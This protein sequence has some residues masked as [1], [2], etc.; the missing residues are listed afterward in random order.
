MSAG[1]EKMHVS[2]NGGTVL[3]A[4]FN[5]NADAPR[6]VRAALAD[7]CGDLDRELGFRLKFLVS[8]AVTNRVLD[9]ALGGGRGRIHVGFSTDARAARVTVADV[10]FDDDRPPGSASAAARDLEAGMMGAFSDSWG[11]T[12]RTDGE[13]S[14]WFEVFRGSAPTREEYQERFAAALGAWREARP[15]MV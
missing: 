15:P 2:R 6:A 4:E 5:A 10:D 11:T 3:D 12:R 14:I 9:Q 8:E 7:V 13:L 1:V